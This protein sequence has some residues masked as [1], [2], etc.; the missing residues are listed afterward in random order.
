METLVSLLN[1]TGSVPRDFEALLFVKPQYPEGRET[2]WKS[3]QPTKSEI[4][5]AIVADLEAKFWASDRAKIPE[6]VPHYLRERLS[7]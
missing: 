2:F 1:D 3:H 5:V 4:E 6:I 7:Q